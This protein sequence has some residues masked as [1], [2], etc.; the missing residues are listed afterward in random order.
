MDDFTGGRLQFLSGQDDTTIEQVLEP[1]RGRVVMFS[2]GGE[3]PHQ[4]EKV[5]AGQRFVLSFWFTCDA[6]R[7]FE[8]FLDGKSHTSF[9]KKIGERYDKQQQ[10]QQQQQ[11]KNEL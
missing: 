9:S 1:R 7:E 5:T 2:S 11:V 6:A 4:V 8:I 3:N 10:Q